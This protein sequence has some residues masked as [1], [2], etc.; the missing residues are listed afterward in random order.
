MQ[1]SP[2]RARIDSAALLVYT[3]V[4]HVWAIGLGPT[5]RDYA[6]LAGAAD[7]SPVSAW[8]V[9]TLA[10]LFGAHAFAYIILNIALLYGVCLLIY[11]IH[12]TLQPDSKVWLGTL[13]A[14]CF[15][16]H[17][18]KAESVLNLTGAVELLPAALALVAVLLY[19][20][21]MRRPSPV[22]LGCLLAAYALATVPFPENRMLFAALIGLE[23]VVAARRSGEWLSRCLSIAGLGLFLAWQA[24]WSFTEFDPARAWSPLYFMAYP[25]GFLPENAIAMR[26]IPWYGWACA[27]GVVGGVGVVLWLSRAPVAVAC[28]LAA[29]AFRATPASAHVDPV[30][31]IGGGSMMVPLA[32]FFIGLSAVFD[33][34]MTHRKWQRGVVSGTT[35][36]AAILFGMQIYGIGAWRRAGDLVDT[37][38]LTVESFDTT[39]SPVHVIPDY[40]YFRGAPV[41]LSESLRYDTPFGDGLAVEGFLPL[42]YRPPGEGTIAL[43]SV[44][45][46]EIVVDVGGDSLLNAIPWP[47]DLVRE[48]A[49]VRGRHGDVL[50]EAATPEG[51]RFSVKRKAGPFTSHTAPLRVSGERIP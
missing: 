14:A 49:V 48:G 35:L 45:R 47:Y 42:N 16:A 6:A 15:M 46:D 3:L 39:S 50:V 27:A 20:A 29:L 37:T 33:R 28:V 4:V 23:V 36:L 38:R 12:R 11:W 44:E 2:H 32:F 25:I 7:L 30:H 43:D 51:L 1:Q 21:H 22:L 40:Q 5:G 41:L 19:A 18:L 34:M 9:A 17:P 8:L 26:A 10:A 13:A 24:P 31:L